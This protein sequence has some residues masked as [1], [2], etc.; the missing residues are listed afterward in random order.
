M[1]TDPDFNNEENLPPA[2]PSGLEIVVIIVFLL[3]VASGT[4]EFGVWLIKDGGK[5]LQK[6]EQTP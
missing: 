5:S 3:F 1:E 2:K 6:I 4:Y